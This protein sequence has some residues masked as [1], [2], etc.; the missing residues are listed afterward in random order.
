MARVPVKVSV[1]VPVY[2][3]GAHI[4]PLIESL[5]RQTLPPDE[6]EAVFVDDGSTDK[7]PAL[8]D[9]L[10]AEHEHFHVVHQPNSGWPGKPRN[11]GL[12]RAIGDFVF[13]SDNDDWFG[14]EALERM[15]A[16]AVR[17]DADIVIGKMI[18]HDRGVPRELF[19]RNIAKATFA[20]APLQDSLTPHKLFRRDFLTKH[21][22][23]FPEGKRRLEDHLF[24]MKAFFAADGI[25]VLADYECYHHIRRKDESNA[26]FDTIEP[27][28]YFGY[29]RE[30]ID[31]VLANT[32]PGAVRDRVLRRFLR[33]EVLDRL[34]GWRF[35]H[36]HRQERRLLFDTSRRLVLDTMAESVD[37]AL[38]GRQRLQ[39]TV[40]RAGD[41][42]AMSDLALWSLT[43]R[44]QV[45]TTDWVDDRLTVRWTAVV[46]DAG[47]LRADGE[48][49]LLTLPRRVRGHTP[50][51]DV[52]DDV[53]HIKADVIGIDAD[54]GEVILPG[55]SAVE[56]TDDGRLRVTGETT[57]AFG[58]GAGKLN[59]GFWTLRVRVR[60]LGW[61]ADGTPLRWRRLRPA[62]ALLT[63]ARLVR[64]SRTRRGALAL[65]VGGAATWLDPDFALS[66]RW[67]ATDS[68][69]E[70]IVPAVVRGAETVTLTVG[71]QAVDAAATS[72]STTSRIRLGQA[73]DKESA[74]GVRV[75]GRRE[76]VPL[77]AVVRQ[78]GERVVVRR[79]MS[80]ATRLVTRSARTRAIFLVAPMVGG[81]D[82][83]RRRLRDAVRD[84]RWR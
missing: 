7:T 3:P 80:T 38:P 21:D 65:D 42:A 73:P 37:A 55:R 82:R 2:N 68:E 81:V 60:A 48:R 50:P 18:G 14:D 16:Y 11:V 40:L 74:V 45:T 84:Q 1:V 59:S 28:S 24:V 10:A 43:S 53:A 62:A 26:G 77:G 15:H 79:P 35:V 76:P 30:T 44:A 72:D 39:A 63:G 64:P 69:V 58:V 61:V 41:F 6:F 9:R 70:F 51:L 27:V 36:L 49:R 5:Q 33:V 29:V 46:G 20:N 67:S 83:L 25:S 34:Q 66:A 23:R 19:R 78:Q 56:V 4:K 22:L 57:I 47:T 13:F 75:T 32:E 31:V 54:R 8:L 17:N 12:D 71:S 52:T